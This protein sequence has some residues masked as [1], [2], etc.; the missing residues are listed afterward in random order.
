[1]RLNYHRLKRECEQVKDKYDHCLI[2]LGEL[3][4]MRNMRPSLKDKSIQL[5]D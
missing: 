4:M 1:M 5:D 3:E 2:R